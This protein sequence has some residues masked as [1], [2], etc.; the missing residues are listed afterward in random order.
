MVVALKTDRTNAKKGN[1]MISSPDSIYEKLGV[2][3]PNSVVKMENRE[4]NAVIS[5]LS[6]FQKSFQQ[7]AVVGNCEATEEVITEL[8]TEWERADDAN[9]KNERKDEREIEGIRGK[10]I[11][12]KD[13]ALVE[14]IEC[15]KFEVKVGKGLKKNR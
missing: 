9:E 15:E 2:M 3:V 7:G 10:Q 5:N 1:Y 4:V 6:P 12:K 14:E 11:Y 8:A 13:A